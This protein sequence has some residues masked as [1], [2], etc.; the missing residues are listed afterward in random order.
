[1][2]Y[3]PKM[4]NWLLNGLYCPEFRPGAEM[5]ANGQIGRYG[6]D[7]AYL[8][9]SVDFWRGSEETPIF[10]GSRVEKSNKYSG[11]YLY[12]GLFYP[13]LCIKKRGQ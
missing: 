3:M 12:T 13:H 11:W 8:G 6:R 2:A 5:T 1:M 9:L 4:K 10:E 7:G